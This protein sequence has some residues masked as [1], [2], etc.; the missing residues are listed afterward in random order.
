MK[1]AQKTREL[2]KP[3]NVKVLYVAESPPTGGTFFYFENSNLYFAILDAFEGYFENISFKETT[4]F[5]NFFKSIGFYLEDLCLEP[6]NKLSKRERLKKRQGG[7]VR[8]SRIIRELSPRAVIILMKGIE[9]QAREAIQQSRHTPDFIG[10]S[11][12]PA[13]SKQ[14]KLNCTKKNI[15]FLEYFRDIG[16]IE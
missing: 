7:I 16:I 14:N 2:F 11:P 13:H 6:V 12:F 15:E 9:N 4:A 10:V 5:L 8:L 3:I 1:D